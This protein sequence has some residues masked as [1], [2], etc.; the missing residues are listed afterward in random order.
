MKD[1]EAPGEKLRGGSRRRWRVSLVIVALGVVALLG[2]HRDRVGYFCAD[3]RSTRVATRWGVGWG[4]ATSTAWE[5]LTPVRT[6]R[7]AADFG[8][9]DH[10]HTW[11]ASGG[12]HCVV[13][14]YPCFRYWVGASP[15]SA[16]HLYENSEEFRAFVQR[17]LR[18]GARTEAEVLGAF[19]S[20][21]ADA[22]RGEELSR[23]LVEQHYDEL[24]ARAR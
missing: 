12:G 17:Q 21:A 15:T 7:Y 9:A 22:D 2:T 1:V 5:D 20:H 14:G 19:A 24:A 3:C 11:R 8:L 13:F 10:Q 4:S 18:S 6:S 16:A 23:A